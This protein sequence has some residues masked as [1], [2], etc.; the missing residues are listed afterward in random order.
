MSYPENVAMASRAVA[1]AMIESPSIIPTVLAKGAIAEW[2]PHPEAAVV[3]AIF[4]MHK[5]GDPID[6]Q[7]VTDAMGA[8][9]VK[10]CG[11]KHYI[12]LLS[13]DG[14]PTLAEFWLDKLRKGYIRNVV[15]KEVRDFL[16]QIEEDS[17][18][19]IPSSACTLL[20]SI[21]TLSVMKKRKEW[22]EYVA[23]ANQHAQDAYEGKLK[24]TRTPTGL[25]CLERTYVGY[26]AGLVTVAAGT[27]RGKSVLMLQSAL[28]CAKSGK[29]ALIITM[30]MEGL[31]IAQRAIAAIGSIPMT[32]LQTGRPLPREQEFKRYGMAMN[33]VSNYPIALEYHP[34]AT[35]TMVRSMAQAEHAKRPLGCIVIDYLQLLTPEGKWDREE[36]GFS[37]MARQCKVL[38]GELGCTVIVGSQINDDGRLSK[39]RSIGHHSDVVLN[40]EDVKS[41]DDDEEKEWSANREAVLHVAKWRN[42]PMDLRFPVTLEGEFVRFK[43]R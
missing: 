43:D 39:A 7:T 5:A 22:R 21:S 24:L 9:A 14:S 6:F 33:S 4:A 15:R 32:F 19:D 10:R 29:G 2:F 26:P 27:G 30:E 8:D 40:I 13:V 20:H 25:G 37:E 34:S 12:A 36:Q 23:D 18:T 41:K 35:F 31:E 3:A 17:E 42:G 28:E 1:G 16:K 11:G 38:S